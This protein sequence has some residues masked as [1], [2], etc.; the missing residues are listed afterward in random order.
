MTEESFKLEIHSF[1]KVGGEMIYRIMVDIPV[2]CLLHTSNKRSKIHE[3]LF[4]AVESIRDKHQWDCPDN[5]K[6]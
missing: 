2:S 4:E 5:Q 1:E 6:E 3:Q